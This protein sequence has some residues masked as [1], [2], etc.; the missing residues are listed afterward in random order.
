[1]KRFS[2]YFSLLLAATIVTATA[3]PSPPAEAAVEGWQAGNIMS[4]EVMGAYASMSDSQI[5]SFLEAKVSTCDTNG[6]QLSEY[7]G[8]D[9]NGDGKVQRWEWGQANY[10]QTTF[11]C[12]K[13]Y[14]V[15]G[16]KASRIIYDKAQTYRI[17]PKVLIVLLQKEQGLVTDTWPLNVQYRTATGY[18]CPDTAPCDSQ[19]YGLANQLDWAAK[20]FRSILDNSPDWYTPYVLGNNYIQY[21]PE[22]SC[23]GGTVNIANRATQALYNY[24]PYQPNKASLDAGFGSAPCGA[25]GNRNF[26]LYYSSW[27]GSPRGIDYDSFDIPRWMSLNKDTT[28]RDTYTLEPIET[29][30][31]AGLH[32]FFSQKIYLNGQ[33]Y[34]RSQS[35]ADRSF[36]KV[37]P[38]ADVSDITSSP[39]AVPR[40]M[41][42]SSDRYKIDP[43]TGF[44]DRTRQYPAGTQARFAD[45]IV[46]NG[47]TFYRTEYDNERA[48]NLYFRQTG[49]REITYDPF[50]QPR[51]MELTSDVQKLNPATG[52][53]DSTILAAKTQFMFLSKV[54][55]A[56]KQYFR[57]KS[58]TD[59][60]I[61]LAI[62]ASNVADIAYRT[63]SKPAKYMDLLRNS[64]KVNPRTGQVLRTLDNSRYPH[65]KIA[66]T[67]TVDGKQFYRTET[68]AGRGYDA[69][70]PAIDMAEIEYIA[71]DQPRDLQ[72][73]Q[74]TAKIDP[75]TGQVASRVYEKGLNVR[76]T[77]K[78]IIN[79][80]MYLRSEYDTGQDINRAFP[81]SKLR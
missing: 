4:N 19:Y 78:I 25:Y 56:G 17:N 73:N 52:E 6:Q 45:E 57:T 63:F 12:L 40:Y 70:I 10:N 71:L 3:A 7:G 55:I 31:P 80:E 62:P 15:N 30:L 53:I 24:T 37:I 76:Y 9:L 44:I 20:M 36:D 11:V 18:G 46:V 43:I 16:V 67:I 39:L 42:L 58:D 23:G 26:Y 38:L 14:T 47:E 28:K 61:N 34:V 50:S 65:I 69:A 41:E 5:Q 48:R 32:I 81:Y 21:N 1:M 33:W 77:T 13:D 72:L 22:S 74:N 35:D 79:G 64:I 49:V 60:N 68:D 27:F 75:K 59:S 29:V 8:P 2:T 51:F 54:T 66:H